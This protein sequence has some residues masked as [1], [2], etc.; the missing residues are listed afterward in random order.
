MNTHAVVFIL[1][2]E[3]HYPCSTAHFLCSLLKIKHINIW[4]KE[5]YVLIPASEVP[6]AYSEVSL[7]V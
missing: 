6:A 5:K 2:E 7:K 4:K 3:P 1:G